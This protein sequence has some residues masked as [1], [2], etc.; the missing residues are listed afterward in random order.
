MQKNIVIP[1]I[2]IVL[3]VLMLTVFNESLNQIDDEAFDFISA[4]ILGI[5]VGM[6][7]KVILPKKNR[8]H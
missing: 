2:L 7:L 1:I 6:L 4:L 8:A 5:G 3:G